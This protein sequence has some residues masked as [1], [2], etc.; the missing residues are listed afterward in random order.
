LTKKYAKKLD[1]IR[2]DLLKLK[3]EGNLGLS[4][5]I[6]SLKGILNGIEIT[7]KDI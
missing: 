4:K 5:R 3:K 2:K 1:K 7:E 6:I